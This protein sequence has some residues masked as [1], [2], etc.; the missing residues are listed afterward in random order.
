MHAMAGRPARWSTLFTLV[1]ALSLTMGCPD[2]TPPDDPPTLCDNNGPCGPN[3]ACQDIEGQEICVCAEGFAICE[4]TC[5]AA[6][7]TCGGNNEVTDAGTAQTSND[8]DAGSAPAPEADSGVMGGNCAAG[9][10]ICQGPSVYQCDTANDDYEFVELCMDD[11][12]NGACTSP[13]GAATDKVSYLGCTFWATRLE[14]D[15]ASADFSL[16]ISSHGNLPIEATITTADGSAVDTVTVQPGDLSSVTLD[17]LGQIEGTGISRKA[18]RISTNGKVTIHQFNPVNDESIHSSDAT[19]LLPVSALGQQYR[20]I[21]WPT[22]FVSIQAGF[23]PGSCTTDGDCGGAPFVCGDTGTCNVLSIFTAKM[24]LIATEMDATALTINAP[25]DVEIADTNGTSTVYP[26]G[27]AFELNL[28]QGDVLTLSTTEVDDADLSGMTVISDKK[29]AVFSTNT[30]AM[31]PHGTYACDHI[32][33]QLFPSTTW[34]KEYVA[35]KFKPRG[36]EPDFWRIVAN[37]DNTT[38]TTTPTVPELEN[39]TLNAGQMVQFHSTESFH[40]LATAPVSVAQFMVGSDYPGPTGGCGADFSESFPPQAASDRTSCDIPLDTTCNQGIG[41]PAFLLNVP[42]TQYR[43]DYTVLVPS[44][45]RENYVSLILPTDAVATID[46]EV[47]VEDTT[48]SHTL[49]NTDWRI[50]HQ[51]LTSGV[52]RITADQAFGLISYGYD[53]TVSYAYPGGLN[54]ETTD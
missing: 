14:N 39:L 43:E 50:V 9:E 5:I 23:L 45:Y 28:T 46:D 11:C 48:S 24:S 32:E 16:T 17:T 37:T 53:C 21:G 10:R 52:H 42:A 34:G 7:Q 47:L 36:T 6:T 49:S 1:L 27:Q 25:V 4:G 22:E 12:V 29:V 35:A 26:T 38:F 31:I 20:F 44:D 40:L 3:E 18:Y 15:N 8:E 41:D 30:C 13:C 2:E 54:L 51:S 19:L 33:Q